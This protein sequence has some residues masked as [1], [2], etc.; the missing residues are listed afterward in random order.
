VSPQD[1]IDTN[2]YPLHRPT[3]GRT[4]ELVA[5]GREAMQGQSL[6]ALPNFVRS[7]GV[8]RI[9]AEAEALTA[10]PRRY[11]REPYSFKPLDESL[12]Q[13]HPTR[14]AQS[15]ELAMLYGEQFDDQSALRQLYEWRPLIDFLEQIVDR[16]LY[17]S[18]DSKYSLMT[19]FIEDGGQH[20]W[21][22]DTNEFVVSLMLRPAK[23]GGVFEYVPELRSERDEHFDQVSTVLDGERARVVSVPT[24][25]GTLVLFHGHH[26]LHRVSP[27][28]GDTSRCMALLSYAEREG[29][30]FNCERLRGSTD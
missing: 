30:T 23:Q 22:F 26:A 7:N 20:G 10:Q 5:Q 4:A 3:H 15:Y 9:V 16:P 12:A 8:H 28:S 1:L 18:A 25:S 19:T 27:V 29:Q 14:R 2:R 21:H 11:H 17:C 24:L 6:F 13:Q